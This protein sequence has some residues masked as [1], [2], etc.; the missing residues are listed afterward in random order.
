M[1]SNERRQEMA[2]F[3]RSPQ[4]PEVKHLPK[5]MQDEIV[6][7]ALYSIPITSWNLISFVLVIF[8]IAGVGIWFFALFGQIWIKYLYMLVALPAVW[9]WWL[10]TARP[11]I[12]QI[13]EEITRQRPEDHNREDGC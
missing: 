4:L 5:E 3:W 10:N 11:R 2:I 13:A 6:E 12:R 8:P 7:I 1:K 9:L